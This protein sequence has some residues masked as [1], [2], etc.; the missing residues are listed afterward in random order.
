MVP[1]EI[2]A[3]HGSRISR[4]TSHLPRKSLYRAM[5]S[6]LASTTTSS[7]DSSVNTSALRR[8]RQNVSL[9]ST[10]RKFCRPTKC[11]ACLPTVTSVR[12]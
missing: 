2:G 7:C 12:L 1:S 11:S 5:A 9:S 4:R 10:R 8:E 6:I 3:T